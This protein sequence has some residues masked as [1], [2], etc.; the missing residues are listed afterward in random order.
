MSD[1]TKFT[2]KINGW[3]IDPQIFTYK[4]ICN[5]PGECCH[6]GVFIDLKEYYTI[7]SIKYRII[8]DMDYTQPKNVSEWFEEPDIDEDFES[9]IAVGTE[10]TNDKCVFLDKNGLC[11]LQK[12]ALQEGKHKWKYKPIYCVLFPLTTF[13]GALTIDDEHIER[14]PSCNGDSKTK[15]TIFEACEEELKH[16]F[17]EEGFEELKQ[18]RDEYIN[19]IKK[20][21]NEDVTK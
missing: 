19:E 7:L 8:D 16:F 13:E 21:V 20:G 12:I 11:T 6:Y 3:Y 10:V 4:F 9:G 15:L 17:G 5:C 18:Y 14:L 2:K 1:N